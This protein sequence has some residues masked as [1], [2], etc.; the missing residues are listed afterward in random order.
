MASAAAN[1]ISMEGECCLPRKLEVQGVLGLV[2]NGVACDIYSS[3]LGDIVPA[4][5]PREEQFALT[6][7]QSRKVLGLVGLLKCRDL[8]ITR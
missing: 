2:E 8:G 6:A 4:T 1:G 5:H 7:A 3:G